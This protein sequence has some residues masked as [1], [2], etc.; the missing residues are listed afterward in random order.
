MS[1][2]VLEAGLPGAQLCVARR[3][4]PGATT[5]TDCGREAQLAVALACLKRGCS[6]AEHSTAVKTLITLVGRKFAAAS[7]LSFAC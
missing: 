5:A 2:T 4:Y 6:H 7:Q 1:G 3:M